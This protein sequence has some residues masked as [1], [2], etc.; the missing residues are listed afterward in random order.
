MT[1]PT[2]FLFSFSQSFL[3]LAPVARQVLF[4]SFHSRPATF[5]QQ[6]TISSN[7]FFV[8]IRLPHL[9]HVNGKVPLPPS[10]DRLSFNTRWSITVEICSDFD[11]FFFGSSRSCYD[12]CEYLIVTYAL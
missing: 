7:S 11:P 6:W 4:N 2:P 5:Y 1:R 3:A 10:F 12:L 9:S 8:Y